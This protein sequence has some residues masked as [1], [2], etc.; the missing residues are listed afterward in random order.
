MTSTH[1]KLWS[2]AS[3]F[4]VGIYVHTFINGSIRAWNRH[5]GRVRTLTRN[6]DYRQKRDARCYVWNIYYRHKDNT[7]SRP[8]PCFNSWYNFSVLWSYAARGHIIVYSLML[9]TLIC[10]FTLFHFSFLITNPLI[11]N[12]FSLEKKKIMNLLKY[13]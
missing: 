4:P 8:W 3:L 9:A 2:T 1:P 7:S 5:E 12:A 6:T 13:W 10:N 11:V